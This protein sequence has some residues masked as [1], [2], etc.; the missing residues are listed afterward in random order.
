MSKHCPVENGTA[1]HLHAFLIQPD[2]VHMTETLVPVFSRATINA[3]FGDILFSPYDYYGRSREYT[4]ALPFEERIPTLYFRGSMTGGHASN[5][6]YKRFQRHRLI[7][8]FK[9][10]PL[11]N[12]SFLHGPIQCD[13][14]DC[15]KMQQEYELDV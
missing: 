7:D 1:N 8:L 12:V 10:N 15:K 5:S 2:T 11:F 3:C 6:N 14:L 4:N 13:E 9:N